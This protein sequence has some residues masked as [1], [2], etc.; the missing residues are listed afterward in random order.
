MAAERADLRDERSDLGLY[1]LGY[2]A[3]D[4]VMVAT[5]V[6]ALGSQKLTE[7]GGRWL[8]LVSG[9]VMLTLGAVLVGWPDWLL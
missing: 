7:R 4:S 8:K 1:I 2:V 3:D 9:V 6:M 5:A